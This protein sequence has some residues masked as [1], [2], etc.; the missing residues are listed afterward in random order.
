MKYGIL[1]ALRAFGW[2]LSSRFGRTF[3]FWL[4]SMF[5]PCSFKHD[6]GVLLDK[7][8]DGRTKLSFTHSEFAHVCTGLKIL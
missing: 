7:E 5:I 2:C 6:S 3:S 4:K 8:K 1:Q